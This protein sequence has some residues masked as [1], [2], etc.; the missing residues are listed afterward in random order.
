M[1]QVTQIVVREHGDETF[2]VKIGHN[3]TVATS[4]EFATA[5]AALEDAVVAH[6]D[7][8]DLRE[9]LQWEDD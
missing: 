1:K 7:E 5:A 9:L 2:T 8:D 4:S 6:E 3:E